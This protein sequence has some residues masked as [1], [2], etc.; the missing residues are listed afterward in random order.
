M[1][2]LV[3][4]L[5]S[6]LGDRSS[7]TAGC[8]DARRVERVAARRGLVGDGTKVGSD[9]GL[10]V[11]GGPKPLQLWVLCVA[12]SAIEEDRLRQERFAPQC[13]QAGGVEMARMDGPETHQIV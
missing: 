7:R 12:A 2:P 3:Q 4:E 5:P 9:A 13:N 11:G 1:L 10:R 6:G 8:D